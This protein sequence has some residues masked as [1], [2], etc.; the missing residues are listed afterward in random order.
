MIKVRIEADLSSEDLEAALNSWLDSTWSLFEKEPPRP[1]RDDIIQ[2]AKRLY[3][4][5]GEYFSWQ[6]EPGYHQQHKEFTEDW[7]K[8]WCREQLARMFPEMREEWI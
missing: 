1:I 7:L 3:R 5:Y 6:W 2:E 8:S 4:A